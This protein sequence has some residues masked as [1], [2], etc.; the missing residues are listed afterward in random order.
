MHRYTE[1]LSCDATAQALAPQPAAS[2]IGGIKSGR[3]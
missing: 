1:L 2:G 3:Q